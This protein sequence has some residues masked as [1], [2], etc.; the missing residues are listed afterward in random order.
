MA[1]PVRKVFGAFEKRTPGH[2]TES[3]ARAMLINSPSYFIPSLL[4]YH[5]WFWFNFLLDNEEVR[6]LL[7][8]DTQVKIERF[9]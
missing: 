1:L 7:A 5:D 9:Y 2:L 3:R 8:F 6:F 4:I